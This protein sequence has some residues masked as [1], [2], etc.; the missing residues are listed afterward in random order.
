MS[1]RPL[2]PGWCRNA[3]RRGDSSHPADQGY[4]GA[5]THVWDDVRI[6]GPLKP[7]QRCDTGDALGTKATERGQ[8]PPSPDIAAGIP[9]PFGHGPVHPSRRCQP[10]LPK[11]TDK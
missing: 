7:R 11:V 4:S 1:V 5:G 10:C 8:M 2:P 6:D 3:A 9:L